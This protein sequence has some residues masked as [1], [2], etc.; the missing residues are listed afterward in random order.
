VAYEN[1]WMTSLV[2]TFG[3]EWLLSSQTN[4]LYR[5]NGNDL[6]IASGKADAIGKLGIGIGTSG[7]GVLN[8]NT[9]WACAEILIIN[10]ELSEDEVECVENTYFNCKYADGFGV[11][12]ADGVCDLYVQGSSDSPTG[13]PTAPTDQPTASPTTSSP[14]TSEPTTSEPTTMPSADPSASP[15][16]PAPTHPGEITCGSSKSGD[17]SGNSVEFEVRMPFAGDLTI[18]ASGS[19][20]EVTDVSCYNV[21]RGVLTAAANTLTMKDLPATTDYDCT[22]GGG[23][24][25]SSGTFHIVIACESDA[26]TS[27]PT[28]ASPTTSAPTT[29]EP[30]TSAPTTDEPT[31][32]PTRADTICYNDEECRGKEVCDMDSFICVNPTPSPVTPSPTGCCYGE[33]YKASGKC[34]MAME[35]GKC[36]EKARWRWRRA[37]ARRRAANGWPPTTRPIV[38]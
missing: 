19:D 35:A 25:I 29:A 26:P 11:T 7:L 12:V 5:G 31:S 38:R 30:T 18:D 36:A 16:T 17:Y 3:A 6:T 28:T 4:Q 32:N 33:S 22:I 14:T 8:I 13:S 2:D 10:A 24:G 27:S 21:E 23:D 20:F 1:G 9:D 15:T 34:A 37:N